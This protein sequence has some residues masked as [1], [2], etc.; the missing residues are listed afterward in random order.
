MANK[1][2]DKPIHENKKEFKNENL[3]DEITDPNIKEATRYNVRLIFEKQ[4]KIKVTSRSANTLFLLLRIPFYWCVLMKQWIV[5]CLL[6]SCTS[7]LK[8][9]KF[10]IE[11][12]D[13]VSFEPF[14]THFFLLSCCFQQ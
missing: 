10:A 2:N 14:L 4:N 6:I 8:E 3:Q 13:Q 7:A 1:T 12:Q 11:P 9:Q 5:L